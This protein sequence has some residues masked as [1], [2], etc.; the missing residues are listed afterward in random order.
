M[1]L[2]VRLPVPPQISTHLFSLSLKTKQQM[3]EPVLEVRRTF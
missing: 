3:F 1:I 2:Q